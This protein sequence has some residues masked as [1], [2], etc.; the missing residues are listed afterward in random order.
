MF[1]TDAT[2]VVA[3]DAAQ[4]T[5][6][7]EFNRPAPADVPACCGYINRGVALLDD[8]VF[9]GTVDA[10]LIALSARTGALLWERSVVPDYREGYSISSAPLAYRDLV[11]TGMSGGVFPTR[12]FLAA[13]DAATGQE[14]WRFM[15]IPGPDEP[16]HETW[17]QDTWRTGGGATWLTG[18]YDPELDIL[19]W[20]VGN[21]APVFNA[22]ARRGDN[23]FTDSVIALRGSSGELL[24][25]F[26]FTP[27]DDHDW[28]SAQIPVVVDIPN[29]TPARQL[30][31]ANRNGF[32]Y[33]L[34]R[35]TGAF[36]RGAP[37]VEQTWAAGLDGKGRPI[38]N[39]DATPRP[40]GTLVAPSVD[41]GTNWWP[42]T[43]DPD[44]NLLLVPVMERSGIYFSEENTQPEPGRP[45]FAGATSAAADGGHVGVL[46]VNPANGQ[47][48]WRHR[49][50]AASTTE[51][52]GGLLSTRAGL[53]FAS[54]EDVFYVLDS[55]TG[56]LMWSF[57]TGAPIV[58]APIAYEADGRQYVAVSAGRT[59]IAFSVVD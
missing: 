39:P 29:Q 45:F 21:P 48:M 5:K 37:F 27:A 4:G 41:G 1:A 57:Q 7:W 58:A 42:P 38:R 19:Y 20:G 10:R 32:F 2:R 53:T 49:R 43:F 22:S 36:L 16:G 6:L 51:R 30:L 11:V 33:A 55:R 25:H 28:D 44:L 3:L 52:L 47:V 14:R 9:V 46:A 50:P 12:G 54:H 8:R 17:P 15:T 34:N 23:L 31:W 40:G 35:E 24:W 59:L 26:Q 13:Y 56:T 18:S